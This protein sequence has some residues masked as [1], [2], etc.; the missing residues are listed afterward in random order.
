MT[1]LLTDDEIERQLA[2]LPDWSRDGEAIVAAYQAPTF[3]AA[4][5]LVAEVAEVAEEMNHHPDIDIRWRRT[6]WLLTTHDVGGLSQL[7]IE[8]AHRITALARTHHA[9]AI[10]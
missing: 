3:P 9:E 6:R 7:D 5:A 10:R 2:D 1:R 4:I 8:Q